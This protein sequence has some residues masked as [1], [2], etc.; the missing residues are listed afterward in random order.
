MGPIY[1]ILIADDDP[2][3]R[4]II[5]DILSDEG[6]NIKTAE[7]GSEALA[8]VQKHSIDL[9][10]LD[11]R[12]PGMD[13]MEVLQKINEIKT[14]P[15]VI[16]V[17]AHGSVQIAVQAVHLGALDFIEKP[18]EIER[19]LLSVKNALEQKELRDENIK[20][21]A[22]LK[23]DVEIIGNS[24][25]IKNIK[26]NLLKAA[27]TEA[28]VLITGDN[29]TG[30]DLVAKNIHLNSSRAAQPFILVNCAAIPSQLIESELFGHEKGAF[31]GAFQRHI[32]RFESADKGTIFLNEIAEM[33]LE[34]QAKLLHVI[35][36]RVIQRLGSSKEIPVDVRIIAATNKNIQESIENNQLRADLFYRLNVINILMPP[37]RERGN[38]ILMLAESFLHKACVKLGVDQKTFTQEA[39][40]L[41]LHHDW[42]GNVREL[43]NFI[44]KTVIFTKGNTIQKEDVLNHLS[45]M[46]ASEMA[47]TETPDNLKEARNEWEKEYILTSLKKHNWNI[48][49]TAESL[50]IQRTYLHRRLNQ[51]GI[52]I[53]E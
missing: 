10:L 12:M 4:F 16:I 53:P 24:A 6:Y 5:S 27:D 2:K 38:D 42:P 33:N 40:L 14:K 47:S 26:Y 46:G 51:L 19:L 35:E 37:L 30:K 48:T 41:L 7:N 1:N 9:L 50:G 43:F 49:N 25:Q 36:N 34:A 8:L 21:K 17:T 20:L 32:G 45:S 44:E 3:I 29:G 18:I 22:H 39:G 11:I 28:T 23:Q 15:V 31:T 52:T 13:G